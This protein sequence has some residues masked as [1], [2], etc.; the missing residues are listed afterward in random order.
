VLMSRLVRAHLMD[1]VR[2]WE[3]AMFVKHWSTKRCIARAYNGYF[4]PIG[5]TILTLWFFQ[6]QKPTIGHCYEVTYGS[7]L[8]TAR[9]VV[10][11]KKRW[12]ATQR[13]RNVRIPESATSADLIRQ[14]FAFYADFDFM[15]YAVTLG[16]VDVPVERDARTASAAVYIE[17]PLEHSL[18]VAS[19]VTWLGLRQ[20]VKE[21]KRAFHLS[22]SVGDVD[23]ICSPPLTKSR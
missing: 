13:S 6:H 4:N 23:Y 22:L 16:H 18:N 2:I 5:W 15:K 10:I 11:Q 12:A 20:T 19:S 21:L 1:D 9:D 7:S 17:N 3:V 8:H 14:F